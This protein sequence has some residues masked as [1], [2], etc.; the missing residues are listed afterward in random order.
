MTSL[1]RRLPV[2]FLCPALA[3]I[4]A[5]SLLGAQSGSTGVI[6]GRVLNATSGSYLNNARI[7]IKGTI[8][9]AFTNE[10]GEYRL[11]GAPEGAVELVAQFTGLRSQS[12]T[13]SVTPGGV[14]TH[15]FTL[16]RA[17]TSETGGV[18][19]LD[20]FIVA[21]SREMN[22]ADIAINEQR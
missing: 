9:E 7:A 11:A 8:R 5:A 18:V 15:D 17:D 20:E 3:L 1:L 4:L 10:N 14:T 6:E 19:K 2:H 21:S 22:A 13:V 16:T 12:S